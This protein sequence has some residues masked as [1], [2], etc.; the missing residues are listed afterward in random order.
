MAI[1][2]LQLPSSQAI[3]PDITPSLANL[4]NTINQ[5]QHRQ[6]VRQSLSQLGNGPNGQLDPMPLLRS[7]D[8][9]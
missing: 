6:E 5:G 2:P 1:Y 9:R 3:T 4:V 8:S 7:D